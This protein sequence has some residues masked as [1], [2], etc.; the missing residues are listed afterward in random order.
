M[1]EDQIFLCVYVCVCSWVNLPLSKSDT[2]GAC[3]LLWFAGF[4]VTSTR[5]S[6]SSSSSRLRVFL[7]AA[8]LGAERQSK[9][10][11]ARA[12]DTLNIIYNTV[13]VKISTVI[14][15]IFWEWYVFVIYLNCFVVH[16]C[17]PTIGFIWK[18]ISVCV[19]E[20]LAYDKNHHCELTACFLYKY[21]I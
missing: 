9:D 6:S 8:V 2:L 4:D 17:A 10:A 1:T 18:L 19:Y 14:N 21:K 5:T 20:L 13:T 12:L 7:V 3:V 11:C 15:R 16:L